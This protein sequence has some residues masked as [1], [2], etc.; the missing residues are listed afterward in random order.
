VL[1]YESPISPSR[2]A[3]A[4]PFVPAYV[5]A[6]I[7]LP[8]G[9]FLF[10]GAVGQLIGPDWRAPEWHEFV[11]L[12]LR[13]GVWVWF[14]PLLLWAM[15]S[16]AAALR[17]PEGP[18][19]V[20]VRVGVYGGV[21]LA[22]GYAGVLEITLLQVENLWSGQAA[23]AAGL[24]LLSA[25]LPV[26]SFTFFRRVLR[27]LRY[28]RATAA[29]LTLAVVDVAAV[30]LNPAVRRGHPAMLLF[31][32]LAGSIFAAPAWAFTA[33]LLMSVRMWRRG[34]G[35]SES[36]A[37][38]LL[39][40]GWV[41]AYAVTWKLANDAAND[42]YARLRPTPPGGC[43]VA[44]AAARGHRWLTR[45]E[46]VVL[47]GGTRVLVTRQLRTLKAAELAAAVVFPR[48]HG[49][50]RRVYNRVGPVLAR[51]IAAP[52]AAD[53]AYVMLKPAE[54]ACAAFLTMLR[55][56]VAVTRPQPRPLPRY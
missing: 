12:F 39:P 50:V 35:P 45:A 38:W 34:G 44:T 47:D 7:V 15:C 22:L 36:R 54:F 8:G 27:G 37:R 1:G 32:L 10:S 19:P 5:L 3:D 46:E 11:R 25:V 17:N 48:V 28:P 4:G 31:S 29:V 6:G 9:C 40:A 21:P 41:G 53:A 13:P 23:L 43:F 16:M 56:C 2:L 52:L 24:F 42:A 51:R 20:A 18:W 26:A 55:G 14:V 30:L 49:A 33:Y